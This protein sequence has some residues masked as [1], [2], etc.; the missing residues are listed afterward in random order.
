MRRKRRLL[1]GASEIYA[2]GMQE[3]DHLSALQGAVSSF[4]PSMTKYHREIR[5]YKFQMVVDVVFHKAVDPAVITQRP[6]TLTS[7]MVAVYAGDAPPLIDVN[8]QLV[9]LIEVCNLNG[10]GW[11]F[12][13]FASLQLTLWHLDPLRARAFVPLPR[14]IQKGCSKCNWDW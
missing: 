7:E 10:S 8:R 5:A 13:N 1:G 14:W 6:V 4:Q 3:A 12:S 2:V 9:N 11:V